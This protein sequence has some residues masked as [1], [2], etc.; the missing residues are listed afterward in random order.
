MHG[1][2]GDTSTGWH[3]AAQESRQQG[4]AHPP[5]SGPFPASR[6][7]HAPVFT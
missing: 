4:V 5:L 2:S 6:P 1:V 7:P 3:Q